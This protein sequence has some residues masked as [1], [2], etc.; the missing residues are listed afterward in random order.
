MSITTKNRTAPILMVT[1][2]ILSALV[3]TVSI[4]GNN[5]DWGYGFLLLALFSFLLAA[6]ASK[7]LIISNE[8][9]IAY[10]A[11]LAMFLLCTLQN[12]GD[13]DGYAGYAVKYATMP[14]EEVFS[15]IPTGA[16]LYSWVISFLFRLLGGHYTPVRAMNM[17]I[18]VC[19]VYVTTDIVNELY[20]DSVVTKKC[21]LWMALFPN[22]IRFSSYFAN[23][24]PLLMIFTLLY[25][26]YSYRYYKNSNIKNLLLSVLFLVPAMILHTAM[27]AMMALTGF[28]ILSRSD[29][30]TNRASNVIGKALLVMLMAAAFVFMLAKGIGT[31][32]FS[33][34]GGVELSVL[35]VSKIGNMSASGRAAYLKG[36][37][38]SNPIMT[39]MFLPVRM[40]YF[41]YTPFPWMIRAVVDLVGFFD[42][43]L[44]IYFS[45]QVYKKTKK[46]MHDLNKDSSEKFVLLLCWVLL[47]IIAMFAA[48][49]S[50]YGTAIRHRCKLFPIML[51]IVGDILGRKRPKERK[52]HEN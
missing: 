32:K 23:R 37:N 28:I 11:R 12:D 8:I 49:T 14:I 29:R 39:I 44:Y 18:S 3:S 51:L 35:G 45:V 5:F 40:L 41:M 7:R 52:C 34:G 38:F 43:V 9:S 15:N 20:N 1:T 26:K 48:V 31:E 50:N 10:I 46:L 42:A 21:A 36:V 22:L 17:A 6:G 47:V 30:S 19:C 24:E 33:V 13:A 25:L 2:A 4:L 27:L 16:Y